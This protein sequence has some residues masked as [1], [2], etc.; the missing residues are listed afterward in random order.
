M[1]YEMPCTPVANYMVPAMFI[2]LRP[3]LEKGREYW[4]D[5]YTMK[6]IK[7]ALIKGDMQLWVG[8]EESEIKLML[9][10]TLVVYPRSV[11]L[12]IPFVSGERV[13]DALYY[14]PNIINWAKVRGAVGIE[15]SSVSLFAW[16]GIMKKTLLAKAKTGL[17]FK[18]KFE[19]E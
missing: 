16:E 19:S 17:A 12:R 15:G 8:V 2:K 4:E 7:L 1:K 14:L 11:W 6:D 13:R 5:Y 10:T 18:L 3:L 9:L